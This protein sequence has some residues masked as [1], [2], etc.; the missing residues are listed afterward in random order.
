[1]LY[2][3][4]PFINVLEPLL[5]KKKRFM[6]ME[7][8]RRALMIAVAGMVGI[9]LVFC[10]LPMRVSGEATVASA[11]TAQVQPG[12]DGVVKTVYVREGDRV[13]KNAVL[14]ELEDWNYRSDVAAGQAR[15]S[16]AMESMNRALAQNDGTLAGTARVKA[17]YWKTELARAQ[18]RLDRTIIRAPLGGVITTPHVEN[19][20]GRRLTQGDS[21]AEIM[22]IS[23]VT[24]DV[25]VPEADATLLQ[26]GEKASIKL[27]SFPVRSLRGEV[28]VISPQG[29][30]ESD[31]RVFVARVDLA[32]EDGTIRPGMQGQG[33]VFVGWHPAG[34]VFFRGTAMW[35]WSKLWS[36]FGW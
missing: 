15:Y 11:A 27:E 34:Y 3:E 1:S 7:K 18:A 9:F 22:E 30:V 14:A 24:V 12:V 4:V 20:V 28:T 31:D 29:E 23:H 25:A 6:A 8:R 35:I 13:T 16:E 26:K 36:W 2:R 21:F 19:T 10:P 17:D 5:Q 32:N 33:K